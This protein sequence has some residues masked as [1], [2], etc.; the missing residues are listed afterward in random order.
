MG[1]TQKNPEESFNN[2]KVSYAIS[3]VIMATSIVLYSVFAGVFIARITECPVDIIKIVFDI[4]FGLLFMGIIPLVLMAPTYKSSILI[5]VVLNVIFVSSEFLDL[6]PT[7]LTLVIFAVL[8]PI[9]TFFF[10]KLMFISVKKRIGLGFGLYDKLDKSYKIYTGRPL[11]YLIKIYCLMNV[12]LFLIRLVLSQEDGFNTISTSYQTAV[13]V[14]SMGAVGAIKCEPSELFHRKS[15]YFLSI[16]NRFSVYKDFYFVTYL[17]CIINLLVFIVLSYVAGGMR[18]I[19]PD[20]FYLNLA[21][22]IVSLLMLFAI[23]P[24]MFTSKNTGTIL[25]KNMLISIAFIPLKIIMVRFHWMLMVILGIAALFL[26][27]YSNKRWLKRMIDL[28]QE[29]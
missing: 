3:Y 7:V 9:V 22:D 23:V 20:G 10:T 5:F 4:E 17:G 1:T 8:I 27:I 21:S 13:I 29:A 18:H 15:C 2:F 19:L 24:F 25:V 6:Q 11:S 28:Y 16:N 12:L 26:M 14:A